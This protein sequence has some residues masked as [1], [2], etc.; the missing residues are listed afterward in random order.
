MDSIRVYAFF[1]C[2]DV[3]MLESNIV[4][5]K[6]IDVETFGI[7]WSYIFHSRIVE[8]QP[9]FDCI[10]FISWPSKVPHSDKVSMLMF[11]KEP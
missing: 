7:K 3:N 9:Q 11:S 2:G 4:A 10:M 8:A 1:R 6:N 5:T